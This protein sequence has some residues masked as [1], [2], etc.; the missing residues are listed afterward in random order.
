[1]HR[2]LTGTVPLT[3]YR[4]IVQMQQKA[5]SICPYSP[6]SLR[7]LNLRFYTPVCKQNLATRLLALSLAALCVGAASPGGLRLV[8]RLQTRS[9]SATVSAA[10]AAV[11]KARLRAAGIAAKVSAEPLG[12][13]TVSL[14]H[15]DAMAAPLLQAPGKIVFRIEP[16]GPVYNRSTA[17]KSVRTD[18]YMGNSPEVAITLVDGSGFHK[19]TSAHINQDMGIY[20]DGK[21][22][23][24]PR[25]MTPIDNEIIIVGGDLS[26]QKAR[27]IA[28]V[29]AGGPLPAA[30]K[31]V[32][33]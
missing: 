4:V 9:N 23:Y 32:H 25:I 8:F 29:L 12:R 28:G 30:V 17:I 26:M 18:L 14:S 31:L 20:L 33:P 19:F 6:H 1:M 24:A 15:S 11:M 10:T 16:H 21:L 5:R 27:W 7:S 2:S 22:L 13:L 3:K